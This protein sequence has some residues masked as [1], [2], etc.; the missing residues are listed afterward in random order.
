[1]QK[2][3]LVGV[4]LNENLDFDHSMEEL[5]NLAEA[6]EIEAAAQVVQNLPM[7]NNAFYIGT[8][9]V[10]EVKNLVSMLDADLSLIHIWDCKLLKARAEAYGYEVKIIDKVLEDGEEISST[11]VRQA[12][13][14]G[15]MQEAAKLL[16]APYAVMGTVVH[17][18][19]L[20]RTL[21]F[22]TV[23]LM[24]P[25]DKLLPPNGVYRSEV[26]CSSGVFKGLTNVCLL[27]TS[28]C[29]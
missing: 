12:V 25:A 1:M 24:P 23:N 15:K 3:I 17:G 2:A 5:E 21:G 7:V 11:R 19:Q 14:A 8:G 27:Y 18:R 29:V 13:E 26:E 22:P 16:G 10:E 4:N 28:R 6:C 20:G 9:K